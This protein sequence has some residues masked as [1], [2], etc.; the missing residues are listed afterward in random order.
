M[1][2]TVPCFN[3]ELPG[4]RG[5]TEGKPRRVKGH[6]TQSP[7]FRQNEFSEMRT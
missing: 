2:R 5:W 1:T 7:G 4:G 3:F 6:E